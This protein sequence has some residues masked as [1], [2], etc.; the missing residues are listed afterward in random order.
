[1]VYV[2][3]CVCVCDF[4]ELSEARKEDV[5]VSPGMLRKKCSDETG[6]RFVTKFESLGPK[7]PSFRCYSFLRNS[8]IFPMP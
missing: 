8:K 2:C 3:V 6:T 5:G 1:M 4:S 7:L